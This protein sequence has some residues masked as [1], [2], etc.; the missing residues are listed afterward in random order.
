MNNLT[1]IKLKAKELLDKNTQF[2][3]KN[4]KK[5]IFT[6][7]SIKHYPFQWFWDSC[8][9]AII[10]THFDVNRA[11]DEIRSLLVWQSEEGFIPH[12][13]FWNRKK[14]MTKSW[15][16]FESKPWFTLPLI[17][18]SIAKPETTAQIQPP[19]I[20]QSVER[21]YKKSGDI[22]FVKET[23]PFL[24]K[25]YKWL[26]STRDRDGDGLISIISPSESGLDFCPAY[27]NFLGLKNPN[28]L[29]LF[30]KMGLVTFLNKINCY[31]L[32]RIFDSDRFVVKDVSM[33]S[34]F[35][36]NLKSLARLAEIVGDKEMVIWAKALAEKTLNS[37]LSKSYDSK[38]DV[39]LNLCG[40]K[41]IKSK[42]L[43][44]ASLMPL[45]ISDLPKFIVQK[46]VEKYILNSD[47]FWL[48]YPIPSVAKDE[49][50]FRPDSELNGIAYDW[51]GGTWLNINWFLIHGLR[52]HGFSE[53]ADKIKEKSIE[54]VKKS[55]F[56]ES[57]NPITGEGIG[58]K[59]FSWTALV[60]DM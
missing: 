41:E 32:P 9:H 17:P 23:F 26:S 24:V 18:I 31:N 29:S 20:A 40:K 8:F 30:F 34:Y 56:Y 27:D 25:Y 38:T 49:S 59:D 44:I 6:A 43:T 39:F 42:A 16:Y 46:M 36:E 3:F 14:A 1:E 35:I 7:P 11:K 48:P 10:W 13:I 15:H 60:I 21:I 57:F 22:N 28:A 5:Y 4:G 52:N 53:I 47:K 50:E 19:I 54:M 55:G 58:A 51:R 45:I 12:V 2:G 37:L 33:N